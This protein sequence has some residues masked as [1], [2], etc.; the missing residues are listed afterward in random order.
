MPLEFIA[1]LSLG[2]LMGG[3]VNGL[4]GFGTAMFAL[5]WWLQILPPLEAVGLTLIMSVISGIPG[6]AFI[7]RSI[8]PGL[9]VRFLLPAFAGIPLGAYLLSIISSQSI[10][11]IVALCLL[12]YGGFFSFRKTLPMVTGEWKFVDAGV[13]FFSGILAGMAS[14]SGA[15]PTMWLSMRPWPKNRTRGLLQPFNLII[16]STAIVG[17][18]VQGGY[19]SRTQTAFLYGLPATV[20]G[21]MIGLWLYSKLSDRQF[22]IT[23]I[24]LM[25]L[26]GC[27]LLLRLA[28]LWLTGTAP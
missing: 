26:S 22:R 16:L 28:F 20:L 8:E 25:V 7:R 10:M 27:M 17:V 14:L 11:L 21:T 5:G 6:V 4:A 15:L 18:Y 9:L 24:V 2:A 13:G 19:N 23:L 3:F 12:V 1:I